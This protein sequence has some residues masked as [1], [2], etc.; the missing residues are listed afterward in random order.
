TTSART[1]RRFA[2]RP[3]WLGDPPGGILRPLARDHAARCVVLSRARSFGYEHSLRPS[4]AWCSRPRGSAMPPGGSPRM[5]TTIE[6]AGLELHGYHGVLE[7]ERRD[8]QR[9]LF[10]VCVDL[11]APPAG[12]HLE[13]TVD[14]RKLA[15]CV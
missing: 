2:S 9:F 4:L 7:E 1:S 11:A 15:A 3:R 10:D 8:G 5:T 13:S 6:L 14:Y 12:D